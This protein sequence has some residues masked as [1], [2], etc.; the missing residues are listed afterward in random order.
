MEMKFYK[1]K[2]CGKVLAMPS[3]S[4]AS[5]AGNAAANSAC[6]GDALVALKANT[7]DAAV[8]KHVPVVAKNGSFVQVTVG[9]VIHPM[10]EKHFIEWIGIQTKFG[11]MFRELAPGAEPKAS[12]VLSEGDELVRAYAYCNLH[13]LWADR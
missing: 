6:C 10:E 13:G 12:F 7:T 9:A 8:E 2:D 5:A 1:C 4:D 3:P 11:F